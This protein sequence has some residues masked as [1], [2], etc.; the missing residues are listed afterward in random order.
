MYKEVNDELFINHLSKQFDKLKDY[1]PNVATDSKLVAV[2]VECRPLPYLITVIK[3]VMYYLGNKWSLQVFHGLEH[4]AELKGEMKSW[5][6]VHFESMG[7]NNIT[8]IEYNNLLKSPS[9]WE[10][11][12]GE[13]VLIFQSDSILLRNGIEEFLKYDYIGAPWLKPKEN[14]YVGNGGL[15][16][17]TKDV[18]LK[19]AK[20]H[21]DDND[22]QEDIFFIKYLNDYNV[23]DIKTAMKFSVE[24]VYFPNPLGLHNPVKINSDLLFNILENNE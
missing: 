6:N 5:G 7:I 3:T 16:L 11:V 8:K 4:E 21:T 13:K 1:T 22:P 20:E 12:K 17:R 24:D 14:S 19:I 2:I 15:S 10:R 9:F 23:A 18:M